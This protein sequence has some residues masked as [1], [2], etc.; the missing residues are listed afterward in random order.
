LSTILDAAVIGAGPAGLT[1]AIYL[2][3][4]KRE[5]MA[6]DGGDSR[7][8][9]IPIS[10]NHP[11]FPDGIR[12]VDLIQRMRAQAEKFGARI[13]P[14]VILELALCADGFELVSARERW[15]ARTVLIATGVRDNTPPLPEVDDAVRQGLLRICPICDGYEAS[16]K[17]VAIISDSAMGAREARFLKTY[18]DH[19]RLFHIGSPDALSGA[20][21]VDLAANGIG[22][23]ETPIERIV[24]D[25][26][27]DQALHFGPNDVERFDAVYSA[28]GVSPRTQL[29]VQAGAALDSSGRLIVDDHQMTSIPG[30]YAA[31]D[32][33]RGLNQ[34]ST[35]EGEAAQAA[36]SMHNR[37]RGA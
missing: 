37:L 15:R 35:A 14:A 36:T 16:G 26:D 5:F 7:A 3:R 23:I 10:R 24:L 12:G 21:R 1:A 6:F 27:K 34:I 19:I 18:T 31:G 22:L 25:P 4:F 9:W 28:L 2:G 32:V 33:V 30:L 8:S 17:R 13:E 29:A 11:G 20:I